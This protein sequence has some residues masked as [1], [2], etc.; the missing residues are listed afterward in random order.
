[1]KTFLQPL[2]LSLLGV[3]VS[4]SFSHAQQNNPLQTDPSVWNSRE[5]SLIFGLNNQQSGSVEL[6]QRMYGVDYIAYLQGSSV[7][8]EPVI[9][10]V[11]SPTSVVNPGVRPMAALAVDVDNDGEDELVYAVSVSNGINVLMP[12]VNPVLNADSTLSIG[13]QAPTS[14]LVLTTNV[15]SSFTAGRGIPVLIKGDFDGDG[16]LEFALVARKSTGAVAIQVYDTDGTEIPQLRAFNESETSVLD[17]AGYEAF[18]ACSG[19]FDGDGDDEIALVTLR[20]A[21]SGSV[22]YSAYVRLFDLPS[23]NSETLVP[24]GGMFY[25]NNDIAPQTGNNVGL[26]NAK[27]SCTAIRNFDSTDDSFDH[28]IVGY[29]FATDNNAQNNATL[30]LMNITDGLNQLA[31]DTQWSGA[32]N[33]SIRSA[34]RIKSGDMNGNRLNNPVLMFGEDFRVFTLGETGFSLVGTSN[35]GVIQNDGDDFQ[36]ASFDIADLDKNGRNNVVHAYTTYNSPSNGVRKVFIRSIEF[37][38]NFQESNVITEE[39]ISTNDGNSQVYFAVTAGNFNGDDLILGEP[40]FYEC[41]YRRPLFIL[42]PPPIHF[43]HLNGENVDQ[44]GCFT[45]GDCLFFASNTQTQSAETSIEIEQ[46][47]DWSV[48]A[49]ASAEFSGLVFSASATM[50]ARYGEQFSNTNTQTETTQVSLQN[51][52]TIDDL[53]KGMKYPVHVYEYPVFNAAGELV[54]YVS[55]AF[56]QYQEAEEYLEQGKIDPFYIPFYEPGNL[57]SYPP[58]GSVVDFDEFAGSG[59]LIYEGP[60][61]TMTNN[62]GTSSNADITTSQ[63]YGNSNSQSWEAGVSASLSAS[64]FGLGMEVNGEYN[65]GGLRLNST[66]IS[67]EEGFSIQYDNLGGPSGFFAYTVKPYIFWT[68]DGAGRLAYQ[69]DLNSSN[70]APTFWDINYGSNPD[71]ALM[72][73]FRNEVYY[74]QGANPNSPIFTRAKS[75]RFNRLY[76]NVGEP[77]TVSLTVHNYSLMATPGPVEVSFYNGNPA[78][79]GELIEDLQGNTVFTTSASIPARGRAVVEVT[80]PMPLPV[81]SGESFVRFYAQLDPNSDLEEV[82]EGNNLGWQVLGYDCDG[83]FSTTVTEPTHTTNTTPELWA[84]PN[85]ANSVLNF[86]FDLP[87]AQRARISLY[88]ANGRVTKDLDAGQLSAGE[89]VLSQ[90]IDDLPEGLYVLQVSTDNYQMTRRVMIRH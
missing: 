68:K 85:P 46:H 82:H 51:T 53:V 32:V 52:T 83:E 37:N 20:Q 50:T 22:Q 72:M 49:T 57:L 78:Q 76:P 27:V 34:F 36:H 39:V 75:M 14:G 67:G 31:T 38:A 66:T 2:L 26:N 62:P 28:L 4:F 77:V 71:P 86:V 55:A 19:D 54:N 45:D 30:E 79:G 21:Q 42:S 69:V 84:W 88:D 58:I 13:Y 24:A 80:F 11:S 63:V 40:T 65:E 7:P 29:G 48:S 89:Q 47:S 12:N 44:S 73:P 59:A 61:Y 17:Q 6:N 56:P 16:Q 23:S 18:D 87:L 25:D 15:N 5:V 81:V 8:F 35:A 33:A 64:G 9:G 41:T 3:A 60:S 10:P 90:M 43:D 1:M 74:T 70:S